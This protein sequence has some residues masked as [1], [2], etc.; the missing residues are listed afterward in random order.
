MGAWRDEVNMNKPFILLDRDGVINE[1][2][3]GYIGS[4]LDWYPIAGSA[5]AIGLLTQKGY[6]V[7]VL[8]NQSGIGRGYYSLADM[9]AVHNKMREVLAEFGGVIKAIY[10]CPHAPEEQ[11]VCRKPQTGLFE[12][13]QQEFSLDLTQTW[14]VG[15]KLSD[16]L[17]G[18]RVKA[19]SVLVKTGCGADT[20]AQ[21]PA[22]HSYPV[23][24][25]LSA[26]VRHL[27]T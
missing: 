15:D 19:Q 13:L 7:F 6:D 17:A 12:Q 16:L 27:M 9:Q 1:D 11:C 23:F 4:P 22:D 18:D 3:K 10:Y 21:L 25:R 2:E 8:T 24:E 26:F 5:E 20:L 14:F